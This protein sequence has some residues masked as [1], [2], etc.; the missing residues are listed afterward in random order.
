MQDNPSLVKQGLDFVA[1][2]PGLVQAG[3]QSANSSGTAVDRPPSHDM[4][5]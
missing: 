3:S 5:Q 4:S 1:A 2:N